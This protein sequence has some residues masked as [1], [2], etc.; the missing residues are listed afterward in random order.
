MVHTL[1]GHGHIC[2]ITHNYARTG[3]VNA[4][5]NFFSPFSLVRMSLAHIADAL[6]EVHQRL[7]VNEIAE[8]S[9]VHANTISR[10]LKH[11]RGQEAWNLSHGVLSGLESLQWPEGKTAAALYALP[12]SDPSDLPLAEAR[13]AH[14]IA[15]MVTDRLTKRVRIETRLRDAP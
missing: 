13:L 9:G 1:H 3:S 7:G 2:T 5:G 10:I 14:V 15:A 11:E 12:D 8:Q 4:V 6:R